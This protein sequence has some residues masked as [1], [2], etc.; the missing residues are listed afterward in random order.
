MLSA[1]TWIKILAFVVVAAVLYSVY[2]S[3]VSA[4]NL[5]K[6][7]QITAERDMLMMQRDD[8]EQRAAAITKEKEQLEAK[9]KEEETLV[10]AHTTKQQQLE[11]QLAAALQNSFT[12]T[13][14][15][16]YKAKIAQ[17]YPAMA[18]SDWEVMQVVSM[19][20]GLKRNYLKVPLGMADTFM[21]QETRAKNLQA[22]TD[23]LKSVVDLQH[24]MLGL[25]ERVSMLTEQKAEA[26]KQGYD[27]AYSAY[28]AENKDLV[29]LLKQPRIQVPKAGALLA[30]SLLG[31]ALGAAL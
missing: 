28:R 31:V 24:E 3:L 18:R 16:E 29:E 14:P 26:Y 30:C 6:I 10:A 8:I 25:Q 7:R 1:G 12:G 13:Q 17:F 9:V 4:K 23:E 21:F 27:A 15:E 22:Q 5:E 19:P 11:Q 20:S 2:S